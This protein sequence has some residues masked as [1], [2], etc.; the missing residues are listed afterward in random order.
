MFRISAGKISVFRSGIVPQKTEPEIKF[1]LPVKQAIPAASNGVLRPT[2]H[3]SH[4]EPDAKIALCGLA[5]SSG[6][7]EPKENK[8]LSTG[9]VVHT[10][11]SLYAEK[12]SF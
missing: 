10:S 4:R 12:S 3:G 6:G 5:A 9:T 2:S 8:N 11:R 7:I 1:L